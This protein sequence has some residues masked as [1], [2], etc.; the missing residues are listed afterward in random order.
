MRTFNLFI[1]Y[2]SLFSFSYLFK[3]LNLKKFKT[4]FVTSS[5]FFI[6]LSMLDHGF[7]ITEKKINSKSEINLLDNYYF[8]KTKKN[9]SQFNKLK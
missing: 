8:I 4:I 5:F 1:F 9:S 6:F 2:I 3:L 7:F